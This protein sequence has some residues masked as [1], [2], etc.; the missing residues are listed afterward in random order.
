MRNYLIICLFTLLYIA[1]S[2]AQSPK[3]IKKVRGAQVAVMVYNAKGEMKETQGV[4]SDEQGTV[5]TEYDALIHATR[6][7]VVDATGKEYHVKEI[8]GANAMY[9][10]AKL[11]IEP[12]KGKIVFLSRYFLHPLA[13]SSIGR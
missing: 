8:S 3:W 4:F 9:N 10:V 2:Y 7:V 13:L 1:P 12:N 11:Q 5:L 6:A